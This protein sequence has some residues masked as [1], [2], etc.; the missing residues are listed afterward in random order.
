MKVA[1]LIRKEVVSV[2]LTATIAEVA[3]KMQELDLKIIPIYDGARIQGM[4]HDRDI[5]TRVIANDIE[6]ASCHASLFAV[7]ASAMVIVSP[8]TELIDAAKLMAERRLDCVCVTDG[9]RLLGVVSLTDVAR[10]SETIGGVV[11]QKLSCEETTS[12]RSAA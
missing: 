7:P 2:P 5:V 10:A 3:K 9:K 6:P 12:S 1:E 8:E 11:L 4:I